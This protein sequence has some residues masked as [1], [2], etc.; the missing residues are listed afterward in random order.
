ML[1]LLGQVPHRVT[2]MDLAL[3][4]LT[5]PA[6]HLGA[7]MADG[8]EVRLGRKVAPRRAFLTDG[9]GFT[10]Y[11]GA[12][13]AHIKA[14]VYDKSAEMKARH[15]VEIPPTLR[16][17][18]TVER[19]VRPSLKDAAAPQ[20]LFWHYCGALLPKPAHV[21][22]W[23]P[24]DAECVM[25]PARRGIPDPALNLRRVLERMDLR[26]LAQAMARV[27]PAQREFYERRL[28]ESLRRAPIGGRRDAEASKPPQAQ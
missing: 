26:P 25:I 9:Q 6:A 13:S 18:L 7:L 24:L 28:L 5:D 20:A 17:E 4:V 15:H 12:R 3:D 22:S 10:V 11:F 14:R 2:R 27:S 1:S 19:H 23:A 8:L 21:P 16:V